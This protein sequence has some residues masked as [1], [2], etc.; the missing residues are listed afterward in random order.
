MNNIRNGKIG[1]IEVSS[2]FGKGSAIEFNEWFNGEGV[3][4][5]FEDDKKGTISLHMDELEAIAT[6]AIMLEMI[7][8][9]ECK[10]AAKL[11]NRGNYE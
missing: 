3:D 6:V 2:V 1:I 9:K 8:I 11:I 5:R 4:F 7:D 10:K